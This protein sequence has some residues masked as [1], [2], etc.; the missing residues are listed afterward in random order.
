MALRARAGAG[1]HK[2]SPIGAGHTGLPSSRV[3]RP[4]GPSPLMHGG[5]AP[6]PRPAVLADASTTE[7]LGARFGRGMNVP[8]LDSLRGLA[9]AA[10]GTDTDELDIEVRDVKVRGR[11][12]EG[13]AR[14][15]RAGERARCSPTSRALLFQPPP[16]T[17]SAS[18]P[19]TTQAVSYVSRRRMDAIDFDP[20]EV[21]EE[22]LPLVYNEERISVFWSARLGELAGRWGSFAAISAPWLTRL[23]TSVVRGTMEQDRG[24]LARD[25]VD[26]L[27][28][29]GPT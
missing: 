5:A 27:E 4:G 9:E 22:G 3:P 21:D 26:N 20:D 28:K 8:G 16:L 2:P 23:V 11:K 13:D 24:S 19:P 25:A 1:L 15:E 6:R 12:R 14:G 10:I 29:L 18:L 17:L 7:G